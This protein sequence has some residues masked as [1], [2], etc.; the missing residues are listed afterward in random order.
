MAFPILGSKTLPPRPTRSINGTDRSTPWW[1]LVAASG[2]YNQGSAGA[3]TQTVTAKLQ[4]SISVKDFGAVGDGAHMA[5]DTAGIKAA[6][7]A[8]AGFGKSSLRA[9]GKLSSG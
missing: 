5:A 2:N 3:V 7:A 1:H 4:Q 6:V 9:G 8:A